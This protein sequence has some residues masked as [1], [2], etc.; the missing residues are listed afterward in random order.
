MKSYNYGLFALLLFGFVSFSEGKPCPGK[1]RPHKTRCDAYYKCTEITEEK[2]VWV[3]A[4][5]E[6]GLIYEHALGVCV[7]P[8]DDWE[9]GM[10]ATNEVNPK[11]P[12]R[13]KQST[14]NRNRDADFYVVTNAQEEFEGEHK[15]DKYDDG[16]VEI[17]IGS[18]VSSEEELDG[19]DE[20]YD[21]SGNGANGELVELDDLIH[22]ENREGNDEVVM[23]K[24]KEPEGGEEGN[25][26]ETIKTKAE[27]GQPSS[28]IDP[29]LTA[30][31]QRLSQLVEGLK[32]T[33][34]NGETPT[35][36]LRPDQLNAFLAHFNIKNKMDTVEGNG[37]GKDEIVPVIVGA[38]NK[39]SSGKKEGTKKLNP[40][41]K[42]VLSNII[43]KRYSNLQHSAGEGGYSNSQIVVNRPEGAVL[44]ALPPSSSSSSSSQGEHHFIERPEYFS[45]N[46][47]KISEDTLKTVLELSKQMIASQNIPSVIRNPAYY[48][49][50]I[51]QPIVLTQSPFSDYYGARPPPLHHEDN[52]EDGGGGYS[53]VFST[54]HHY[55]S[56]KGHKK[57]GKKPHDSS[58][59]TIIHNNVIPLHLTSSGGG[60]SV[61]KLDSYGQSLNLYPP[62]D[63]Q[64]ERPDHLV[65]GYSGNS[66]KP[67]YENNKY[68]IRTT[69]RPS[70]TT[71]TATPSNYG[72]TLRPNDFHP[73][74]HNFNKYFTPSE[75]L[76]NH[77]VNNIF[78]TTDNYGNLLPQGGRP[79]SQQSHSQS[80]PS[81]SSSSYTDED[82]GNNYGAQYPSGNSNQDYG[83]QMFTEDHV[84]QHQP[85]YPNTVDEDDA[86]MITYSFGNPKPSH[87][88]ANLQMQQYP[89]SQSVFSTN[90]NN[91]YM[92]RPSGS[93]SSNNMM[94]NPSGN[95]YN[96]S[97]QSSAN[98][99]NPLTSL[100]LTSSSSAAQTSSNVYNPLSSLANKFPISSSNSHKGGAQLVNIGGNFISVDAFQNSI[101]PLMGGN[102]QAANVE[103]ITCAAGVRQP[104]STDCTRYYVCS[105]KDG[106][107]LSYSCPPYTAFNAETRICDARTYAMC[108]P[109]NDLQ[110]NYSVNE[111]KRLQMEAL[112]AMQEAKR[113]QAMQQ[114]QM[115]QQ[116]QQLASILQQYTMQQNS[117]SQQQQ[118][119]NSL[120]LMPSTTARPQQLT[121][122]KTKK[123]KYYCK[124]GDKI[125]DQTS[126][127]SYFV[128]Y[129][130]AQGQMKGHKMTCSKGLLFCPKTT[131]CTL[132]SKCS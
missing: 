63:S 48:P 71:T 26:Q 67:V 59:T 111:N 130:N 20:L 108:N 98:S 76:N 123:R 104:N 49:P 52:S 43:P 34:Q 70:G 12:P 51:M 128:C 122:T 117:P 129:K 81:G 69:R 58:P 118:Q 13:T 11:T 83:Q 33:Y 127:S 18:G 21:G 93:S 125:P 110:P 46:S 31:L 36:D 68:T 54:D 55:Q 32:Q 95:S 109:E 10:N 115:Q 25:K 53:S 4:K 3:P 30:H 22:V 50:P 88:D 1:T 44:F 2:H 82:N 99:Y 28:N 78:Q 72:H 97:A 120:S 113:K 37:E 17:I 126:I 79:S 61:D 112:K 92:P 84:Q 8:A 45:D 73:T 16:K 100:S 94:F 14:P 56:Y 38:T 121:P 114:Q 9:C 29:N 132:P 64:E 6:E 23:I 119:Q 105:K 87:T 77:N 91:H 27:I 66:G 90:N 74:S 103:V 41:T 85:Q 89:A 107:V 15:N 124:E 96:P 75:H 102:A 62:I 35:K 131:M 40:E 5:C 7:L 106:K 24:E 42:V 86:D 65:D 116:Q 101:L 80:G 19:R 47:P 57:P 39:T 60:S